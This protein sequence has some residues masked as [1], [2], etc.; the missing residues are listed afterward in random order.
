MSPRSQSTFFVASSLMFRMLLSV[1]SCVSPV[2]TLVS[3]LGEAYLIANLCLGDLD[4]L[5]L[6]GDPDLEPTLLMGSGV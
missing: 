6:V 5:C 2:S 4:S 1:N 3:S